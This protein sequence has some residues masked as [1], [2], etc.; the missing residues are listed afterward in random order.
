MA[1]VQDYFPLVPGSTWMYRSTNGLQPLT[2]RLGEPVVLGG[3]QYLPLDGYAASRLFVRSTDGPVIQYWDETAKRA[4]V[5]LDFTGRDFASVQGQC[6]QLGNSADR[7]MDYTGPVGTSRTARAI[8]YSPGIC[9][10]TGLTR[11]VFVP[12]L[13]MV[14]RAETSI[15]GERTLDLVYAQIG[16][17]TYIQEPNIGFTISQT[18]LDKNLA[19]KLIL[20]NRTDKDL[21][22]DFNSGQTFD[23]RIWDTRGEVV[24]TW[25]S[26]R[27]FPYATRRLQVRGEESWHELIPVDMLRP[28]LY[29]IE[30]FLVNSDG[31]KYSAT[32]SF[33][34]P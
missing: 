12:Y 15:I 6:K 18:V 32:A 24:Y 34:L 13:G 1:Q 16:G 21:V 20:Q 9:A 33:N 26:T 4:D 30:G 10:D 5:F 25:S 28:G 27:L 2:L 22:L 31:T 29:S 7:D 19:V 17:I 8:R 11:E 14:Q 23:F 3:Q